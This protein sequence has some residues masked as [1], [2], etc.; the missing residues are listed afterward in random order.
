M[1]NASG[2]ISQ[3]HKLTQAVSLQRVTHLQGREKLTVQS[4]NAEL[5][6]V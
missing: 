5:S 2:N 3:H 1:P 4:L 6:A